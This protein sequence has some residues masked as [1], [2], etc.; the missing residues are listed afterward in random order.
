MDRVDCRYSVLGLPSILSEVVLD[1]CGCPLQRPGFVRIVSLV[2]C[3]V[4]VCHRL[5]LTACLGQFGQSG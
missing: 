2:F 1:S 3:P 5:I 4:L